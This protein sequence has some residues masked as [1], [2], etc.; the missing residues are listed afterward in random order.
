MQHL[1]ALPLQLDPLVAE[2]RRRARRR[3]LLLVVA[4]VA[5]L[6][7]A[8]GLTLHLTGS[9]GRGSSPVADL[10][11]FVG[12]WSG[13]TRGIDIDRSGSGREYLSDGARPVA[14]LRF[15]ILRVTGTPAAVDARIRVTSVHL[16]VRAAF[17]H[18]GPP[19]A[20]ELGTLRLRHGIV[21]DSTTR[22]FFCAPK[23]AQ[24]G[25]CGL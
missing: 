7:G 6:G 1:S 3:R 14:T 18:R 10:A 9:A 2:A 16:F 11:T 17:G 20:G 23:P 21:S 13:H 25:V 24:K 19:R 8:A 22:V 12:H 15:E 5:A 4:L